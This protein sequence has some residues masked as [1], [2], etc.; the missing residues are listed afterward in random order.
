LRGIISNLR[1]RIGNVKPGRFCVLRSCV[2]GG[3]DILVFLMSDARR[4]PPPLDCRGIGCLLCRAG[5]RWP[6]ARLCLFRGG[7]GPAISSQATYERRSAKD[8]G[9]YCEVARAIKPPSNVGSAVRLDSLSESFYLGRMSLRERT[10]P[11]LGIIEPC[12]PSPAKAPPFG[13]GWISRNQA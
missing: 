9:Q 4:F 11:G 6:T 5:S 10:R 8:R 13:P 12:L 3:H 7:A 2:G 1:D